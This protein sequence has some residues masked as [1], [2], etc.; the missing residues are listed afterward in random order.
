MEGRGRGWKSGDVLMK[1]E[2][3]DMGYGTV[4]E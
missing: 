2:G 1:M 3:V 4:R